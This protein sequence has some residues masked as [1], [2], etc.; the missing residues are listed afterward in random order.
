MPK[1]RAPQA[2]AVQHDGLHRGKLLL[3]NFPFPVIVDL[4]GMRIPAKSRPILRDPRRQRI[5]GHTESIEINGSI[6]PARR[7]RLGSNDHAARGERTRETTV[8]L[9]RPRSGQ[10]PAD[11]VRGP[12]ESVEVNGRKFS[13]PFMLARQSTLREVSFVALGAD[14][15]TVAQMAGPFVQIQSARSRCNHGIRAVGGRPGI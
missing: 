12:G 1:R 15:Q 9:G 6:D 11:G 8:P 13:G 3:A 10:R 2:P 7:H 5:V 4:S 14:D